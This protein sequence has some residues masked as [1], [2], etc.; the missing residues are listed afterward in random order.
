MPDVFRPAFCFLKLS[1]VTE[2]T[3]KIK[4]L[5]VN[6]EFSVAYCNENKIKEFLI[7]M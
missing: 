5:S 2:F 4:I 1:A 7:K 6:S 3:G